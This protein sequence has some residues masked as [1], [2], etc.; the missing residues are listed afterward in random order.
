MKKALGQ[1]KQIIFSGLGRSVGSYLIVFLV[2]FLI[3]SGIW[4][5]TSTDS[6]NSQVELSSR[7]HLLQ[8][9]SSFENNLLQLNDLSHQI[10]HD[11]KLTLQMLKHPYYTL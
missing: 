6:I 3:V 11:V 5:K 7:N 4:Y 2:P 8:L 10:P 1:M 9:K